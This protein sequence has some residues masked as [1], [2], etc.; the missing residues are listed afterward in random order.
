MKKIVTFLLLAIS[1]LTIY[2]EKWNVQKCVNYALKEN[3]QLENKRRQKDIVNKEIMDAYGSF[4][5]NISLE[6]SKVLKESKIETEMSSFELAPIPD[7]SLLGI[8]GQT[9]RSIEQDMISNYQYQFKISQPLFMGGAIFYNLKNKYIEKKISSFEIEKEKMDLIYN[10]YSIYYNLIYTKMMLE[11]TQESIDI[12]KRQVD[13]IKKRYDSG[14]A[15]NLDLLQARVELNNLYPKRIKLKSAYENGLK[16]LK[17][18]IGL[19]QDNSFEIV[20][21]FPQIKFDLEEKY[22][23]LMSL[24]QKHSPVLNILQSK[25]KQLNNIETVAKGNYLPNIL[26]TG[27]FGQQ[28]EEWGEDWKDNYNLMLTFSWDLF[29]GF[30]RESNLSKIYINEDIMNDNYRYTKDQIS[31][32]IRTQFEN[33]REAKQ[34]LEAE[35]KNLELAKENLSMANESYKEGLISVLDLMKARLSYNN[36]RSSLVQ[37]KYDKNLAILELKKSLGILG[38]KEE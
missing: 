15:S 10:V 7:T 19:K 38:N 22:S 20:D 27:A 35:E 2:A 16:N 32:A 5:P 12:T 28:K 21:E 13:M 30:A 24:A 23:E 37:A 6:G 14:E 31:T 36:S 34:R 11:I 8:S 25:L 18:V 26:L 1:V 3:I 9:T 4:L 33:I 17:N 29:N